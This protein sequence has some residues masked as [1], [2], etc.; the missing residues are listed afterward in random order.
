MSDRTIGETHLRRVSILQHQRRP[1]ITLIPIG[2]SVSYTSSQ[3][4]AGPTST[5]PS[6]ALTFVSLKRDNAICTPEVD[7]NPGFVV[8]P[9]PFTAKGVLHDPRIFSYAK[10]RGQLELRSLEP[11][12]IRSC[13][14]PR[15]NLAPPSK[16]TPQHS[17]KQSVR[18]RTYTEDR[19]R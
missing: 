1:P 12:D 4:R 15:P 13:S 7:E 2:A 19:L 5:V 14:H 16:W 10:K 18:C 17:N 9:P 3:V 11:V 8:C 6:S